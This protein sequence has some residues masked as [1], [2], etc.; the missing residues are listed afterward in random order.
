[1]LDMRHVRRLIVGGVEFGLG[2]VEE[3]GRS[4]LVL[5]RPR[6]T[7][8]SHRC[9]T[10]PSLSHRCATGPSLS[11]LKGGEGFDLGAHPYRFGAGNRAKHLSE[12]KIQLSM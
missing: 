7:S 8:L 10:G 12:L 11:P 3:D 2:V 4:L 1:M 9:A 5:R 6:P